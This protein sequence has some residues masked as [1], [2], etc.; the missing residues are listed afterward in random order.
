MTRKEAEE[1]LNKTGTMFKNNDGK[2]PYLD[3]LEALGLIK[4]DEPE[5]LDSKIYKIFAGRF[6]KG[7]THLNSILNEYNLKIVEK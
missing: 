6:I 7:H 5:K 1:I 2:Y 4:F 3:G